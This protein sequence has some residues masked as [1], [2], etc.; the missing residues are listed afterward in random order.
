ML[1]RS[2][3]LH[4]CTEGVWCLRPCCLSSCRDTLTWLLLLQDL[5]VTSDCDK[6]VTSLCLR[7]KGLDTFA[8]GQVKQCLV[9][10]GIPE[11]PSIQLAAEVTLALP[12]P[13]HP[14]VASVKKAHLVVKV[15][16]SLTWSSMS[17]IKLRYVQNTAGFGW[18][19]Q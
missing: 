1:Y 10:L 15:T 16:P 19:S 14:L 5:P 12:P 3:S 6:D 4:P 18:Y 11:D 7:N 13:P 2:P 17:R 8:I 9:N